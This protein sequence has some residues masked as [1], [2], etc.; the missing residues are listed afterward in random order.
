[1]RQNDLEPIEQGAEPQIHEQQKI[2]DFIQKSGLPLR[3]GQNR[4]SG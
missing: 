1:M 2:M 3:I 4:P